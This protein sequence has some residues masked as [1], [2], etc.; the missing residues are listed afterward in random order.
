MPNTRD[1][2]SDWLE[3]YLD[4]LSIERG[5]SVNTISA[6]RRDLNRYLDH[7]RGLGRARPREITSSDITSFEQRLAG[8]DN[9]HVPLAASSVGRAVVAVRTFHAFA[10]SEGLV[11]DDVASGLHPPTAGKRLPRTLTIQEVTRLIESVEHDSAVGLRDAALLEMLYGTGARISEVLG[12]DVDE[13]TRALAEPE[14]GLRVTGKGNKQRMVPLGSHAASAVDAWLV[15][16]RPALAAR[17]KNFTAA[18][19]LNT[20]GARLSRQS[21]WEILRTRAGRAGITA[22]I[23]PHSLRH[24]FATHLLEG[25]ADIRVVQEL[26]G[27]ASVSTTQIYTEVTAQQLREVY[28]SSFPRARDDNK[29]E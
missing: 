13:L 1:A 19:F 9:E 28:A 5:L 20:R 21:A 18:L 26:L 4:H 7:L 3:S 14:T 25:G 10:L 2:L 8:G 15:R 22:D 24:S 17:A 11:G 6:Y 27:H 23:G 29:H 16:G 12:L